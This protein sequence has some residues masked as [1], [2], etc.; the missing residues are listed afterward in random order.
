MFYI[1]LGMLWMT[2]LQISP[3][4][5]FI[6]T[7]AYSMDGGDLLDPTVIVTYSEYSI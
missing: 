5:G 4:E 1:A 2:W 6:Y 3:L 7:S